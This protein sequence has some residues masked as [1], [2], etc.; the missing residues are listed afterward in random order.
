MQ[1]FA[2]ELVELNSDCILGHSTPVTTALMRVTRTVPIV[3][4]A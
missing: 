3:F 2:K 4:V 1:A